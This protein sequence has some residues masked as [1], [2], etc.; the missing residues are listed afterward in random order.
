MPK[1]KLLMAEEVTWQLKPRI[2][3]V[4]TAFIHLLHT[5]GNSFYSNTQPTCCWFYPCSLGK[6]GHPSQLLFDSPTN[7]PPDFFPMHMSCTRQNYLTEVGMASGCC[8]ICLGGCG[9]GFGTN[10]KSTGCVLKVRRV[11]SE[12]MQPPGS[13]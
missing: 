7:L 10:T 1:L 3:C 2:C 9:F 11:K 6:R 5:I 12:S 8:S 13:A 4:S